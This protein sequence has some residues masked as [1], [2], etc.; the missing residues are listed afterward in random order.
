M[1]MHNLCIKFNL[2]QM[3]DKY[4]SEA[5]AANRSCLHTQPLQQP[6]PTDAAQ[7]RKPTSLPGSPRLAGS[8]SDIRYEVEG[9]GVEYEV[10]EGVGHEIEAVGVEYEETDAFPQELGIR[11]V[12]PAK[13]RLRAPYYSPLSTISRCS[14]TCPFHC[15][16][17]AE[18]NEEWVPIC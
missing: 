9:V 13:D 6:P 17:L 15:F 16:T 5:R 2:L 4:R 3:L 10:A 14:F 18:S 8:A 1:S 7:L 11:E 12:S